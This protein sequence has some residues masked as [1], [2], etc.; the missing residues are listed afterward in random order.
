MLAAG[1][2]IVKRAP[3]LSSRIDVDKMTDDRA[4]RESMVRRTAAAE[5][6]QQPTTLLPLAAS[7]CAL[8]YMV[9]L[10]PV[11][12]GVALAAAVAAVSAVGAG[13]S[14]FILYNAE[15]PR[16]LRDV[17]DR[18]E[19]ER[20]EAEEA[21]LVRLEGK[22]RQELLG[23]NSTDAVSLLDGLTDCYAGLQALVEAGRN[24]DPLS[25]LLVPALAGETY[26]RGL[27]LLSESAELMRVRS[28]PASSRGQGTQMHIDR[29]LK[30]ARRCESALREAQ[31]DLAAIR[32]SGLQ[33]S[34]DSVIESLR[35]TI[36]HV[37]E[38]Q[39][40]LDDLDHQA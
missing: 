7:T 23:V 12:G 10:S 20:A 30:Q 35:F 34:V 33:L 17:A 16:V 24:T 40:E 14:F 5:A 9:L 13:V 11:L 1:Q 15:Y 38:V 36:R 32:V 6:I 8:L 37:K 26:R 25:V 4:L 3:V 19:T 18:L 22:I 39:H 28:N 21:G 27:G 2:L 29:L 31:A